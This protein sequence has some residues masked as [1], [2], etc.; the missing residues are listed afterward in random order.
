[1]ASAAELD[2]AR[3]LVEAYRGGAE[4]FEEGKL[5]VSV[6]PRF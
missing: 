3:R 4:R 2:R 5:V 6:E 1:M